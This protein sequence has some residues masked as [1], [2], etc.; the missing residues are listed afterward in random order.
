MKQPDQTSFSS[1]AALGTISLLVVFGLGA[2]VMFI[3]G[4]PNPPQE[5]QEQITEPSGSR[6]TLVVP[7][8]PLT[9][10]QEGEEPSSETTTS[11]LKR[12]RELDIE[13]LA[14]Q[15]VFLL[16]RQKTDELHLNMEWY[17]VQEVSH[18][19][20]TESGAVP[21]QFLTP[22][23]IA[24]SEHDLLKACLRLN[25]VPLGT[26]AIVPNDDRLLVT[27][28]PK[29]GFVGFSNAAEYFGNPNRQ[30]TVITSKAQWPA[31]ERH[32]RRSKKFPPPTESVL[33]GF[34]NEQTMKTD[35]PE[36]SIGFA[37]IKH[38]GG[39]YFAP[40]G[41]HYYGFRREGIEAFLHVGIDSKNNYI[42]WY[43]E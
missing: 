18:G 23:I 11:W 29:L 12:I 14:E 32:F 7:L 16:W 20:P 8:D 22:D 36:E 6:E 26:R 10:I 21:V 38:E 41:K 27:A 17:S 39:G 34:F 19:E 28:N 43:E 3:Q 24:L 1:A 30:A 15:E 31:E 35:M 33:V 13:S 25:S 42:L 4:K 9:Q 37:Q 2:S 5:T 40:T